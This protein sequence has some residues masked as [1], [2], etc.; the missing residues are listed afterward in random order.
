MSPR[1]R[2]PRIADEEILSIIDQRMESENPVLTVSELSNGVPLGDRTLRKRLNELQEQDKLAKKSV[3]AQS[4]V[5]WIPEKIEMLENSYSGEPDIAL[6]VRGDNANIVIE[7]KSMN[8][9]QY[10]E[11]SY[12]AE[13]DEET[14]QEII[15][16]I[17]GR[18]T[19]FKEQRFYA[20]VIAYI[21]I[22]E[23]RTTDR[24]KILNK[25]EEKL[26]PTNIDEEEKEEV[27]QERF[28]FNSRRSFWNN[29][30]LNE[31]HDLPNIEKGR[32]QGEWRYTN[33]TRQSFSNVF[34][35]QEK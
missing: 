19:Q 21:Y 9:D 2:K 5:W 33:E 17:S 35:K 31:L 7:V 11:F 30:L 16:E 27:Y 15:K 13:F 20:L 1:G 24:H 3:G 34:L 10:E 12:T 29:F 23:V 4:V 8:K 26:F 32:K 18:T 6:Y 22:Q 25:I 28:G 14:V